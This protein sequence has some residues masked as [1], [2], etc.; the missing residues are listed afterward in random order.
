MVRAKPKYR[1]RN[2]MIMYNGYAGGIL[3]VDL[4]THRT[5][6]EKL[7]KELIRKF[8]GPNGFAAYFLYKELEPGIDPL[9]PK[10][11]IFFGAGPVVGTGLPI[12]ARTYVA[13]KSPLTGL[14]ADGTAGGLW[15]GAL[16]YAGYDGIL[17]EGKGEKPVYIEIVDGNVEIKPADRLWGL[18]TYETHNALRSELGKDTRLICIGPGGENLVKY[19]CLITDGRSAGRPGIGAVMGSKNLKAIA[20]KGR[21][22]KRIEVADSEAIREYGAKVRKSFPTSALGRG[23]NLKGTSLLLPMIGNLGLLGTRNWQKETFDKIGRVYEDLEKCRGRGIPCFQCV[24]RCEHEYKVSEGRYAG[25]TGHPEYETLYS[26]G[27]CCDNGDAASIIKMDEMCDAYGLDTVSTGVTLAF[28]MECYEKGIITEE[29]MDG[30]DLH[31]GNSQAMIAMIEKI[32]RRE[33]FGDVLADGTKRASRR[34]GKGSEKFAMQVKGLEIPGHGLRATRGMA[35]GYCI[36]SRGGTHHDGRPFE[37]TP[38]PQL[39]YDGNIE[40]IE[41]KARMVADITRWTTFAECAG[42]CHFRRDIWAHNIRGSSCPGKHGYGHGIQIAGSI[43]NRRT[44]FHPGTR[45]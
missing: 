18:T 24:S 32:V 23:Y 9:S 20:I 5:K 12:S 19:A 7:D 36:A 28:A 17:V 35:L 40:S 14:W 30:I 38:K 15:A 41:G 33:G 34:I 13:S 31:F 27:S 6:E 8:L 10:N 45:L 44:R 39:N 3:R 26:L 4:S 29:E 1:K 11:K 22:L 21:A 2:E 16:K 25:C 43:R 42:F 37:Y